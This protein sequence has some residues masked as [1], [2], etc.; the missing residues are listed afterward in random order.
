MIVP[1]AQFFAAGGR[2][3]FGVFSP[4]RGRADAAVLLCPPMLHE[5]VRSHRLWA[6]LADALAGQGISVLR[7]DYAGSGDAE[8]DSRLLDV[9]EALIDAEYALAELRAATNALPVHVLG[10]RLGGFVAAEL[11][12]RESM[13]LWLWQPFERGEQAWSELQA[14]DLEERRSTRRFPFLRPGRTRAI[15]EPGLM[16]FALSERFAERLCA[17]RSPFDATRPK[18]IDADLASDR[19]HPHGVDLRLPEALSDWAGWIDISGPFPA[20]DVA[21][22]AK[23]LAAD[24]R[25]PR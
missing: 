12:R 10:V 14:R 4:A 1:G 9:G 13:P 25:A 17:A 2:Q 7:F 11:A 23:R 18:V 8:G 5:Q 16:G 22:V 19:R 24:L 21:Q 15:V 3:L 6:L 20:N